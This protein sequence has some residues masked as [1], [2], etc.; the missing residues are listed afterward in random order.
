MIKY[1][2][3]SE[4][5]ARTLEKTIDLIFN[6]DDEISITEIGLYNCQTAQ[7]LYEYVNSKSFWKDFQEGRKKMGGGRIFKC[8]YTG[9]DNNKDK[10]IE[11]PDWMK[12]ISGN[13]N[14]V[15]NQLEDNS[16]HLII[17]D[18]NHSY[19]YV[20]SDYF[21]YKNK[22]KIG[23]YICF[24]DIKPECQGLD[25]QRIGDEK[26]SDMCIAVRKALTDIGLLNNEWI[27]QL[28]W[29]KIFE[30][31]DENDRCGGFCVFKKLY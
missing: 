21:C 28:G 6:N 19:P 15:Y 27:G 31:W 18:A 10:W 3:I 30:E 14:E 4:T 16:Q 29:T 5:D 8:N 17:I 12:F 1:G 13:S 26:D 9:I 22:V 20:I 23:G 7:G 25:W 2:L 24:H 11:A